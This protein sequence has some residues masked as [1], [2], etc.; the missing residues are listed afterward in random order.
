MFGTNWIRNAVYVLRQ[1][2]KMR[3]NYKLTKVTLRVGKNMRRWN[4]IRSKM[5]KKK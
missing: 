2:T 3:E 5:C 4:K 1:N